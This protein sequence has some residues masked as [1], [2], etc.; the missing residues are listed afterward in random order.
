MKFLKALFIAFVLLINAHA[1]MGAP[2]VVFKSHRMVSYGASKFITP[3]DADKCVEAAKNILSLALAGKLN[4]DV[5]D[6][7]FSPGFRE[8]KK[9]DYNV[10][11][12]DF[13]QRAIFDSTLLILYRNNDATEDNNIKWL[14]KL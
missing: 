1:T 2:E 7:H 13:L 5:K 11:F 9:P 14:N 6:A 10:G 8:A 12:M 4:T 3:S